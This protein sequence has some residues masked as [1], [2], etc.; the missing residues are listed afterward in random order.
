MLDW[1]ARHLEVS[2]AVA[3]ALLV[4]SVVQLAMQVYALVDL[5]RRGAVRGGKKWVWALVVALGSLPG[6]IAYLAAGRTP[7]DVAAGPGAKA[8]GEETVRRAVD[9]LYGPRDGR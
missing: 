7:S 4:L 2:P 5:A 6:A 1:F 9:S 3:A 8:A